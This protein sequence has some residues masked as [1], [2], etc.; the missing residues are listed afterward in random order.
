MV[1]LSGCDVIAPPVSS[2]TVV[3]AAARLRPDLA[4]RRDDFWPVLHLRGGRGEPAP[5]GLV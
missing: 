5:P 4:E 3:H 1:N 2:R